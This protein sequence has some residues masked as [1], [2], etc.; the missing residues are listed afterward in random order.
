MEQPT[1]KSR[2]PA[3]NRSLHKWFEELARELNEAGVDQ[4][5]FVEALQGWEIPI[6]PEFLKQVWKIKQGKMGYGDSTTELSTKQVDEVYDVVNQFVAMN[7][8]VHTP[9]PSNEDFLDMVQ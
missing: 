4:K 1:T 8:G 9:F 2:T 5:V 7:W 6:T 3:Q